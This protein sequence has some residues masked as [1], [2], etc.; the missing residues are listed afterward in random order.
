MP[1]NPNGKFDKPALPYPDT[2]QVAF[3]DYTSNRAVLHEKLSSTESMI[4]TIWQKLLPDSQGLIGLDDDFF[5]LGGHSILATRL[6]FELRKSLAVNAPLDLIFER[7]TIRE[8]ARGLDELRNADLG[9][10]WKAGQDTLARGSDKIPQGTPVSY[11][12]DLQNLLLTLDSTYAP[13]QS[14]FGQQPLTIFLTG[15]TGFLGIFV[16][17]ELLSRHSQVKKVICL[18][19]AN[20]THDAL[21][22][23]KDSAR[24]R[25]V[26]QDNW[27]ND[28][29]LHVV[30]GDLGLE[31][32][33][34]AED[35]WQSI[36][37]EADV[38]LHN[39]AWV[40]R[41]RNKVIK[42]IQV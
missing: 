41:I 36:A 7:S 9:L 27:V 20:D 14:D 1:L 38:V 6:V 12:E 26:W 39:G 30:V 4:R 40:S 32:F 34:L 18:V 8:L 13:L 33:G 5:D 42:S 24:H 37:K 35:T 31:K 2:V 23:I 16:L 22:R 28:Q 17:S 29:R 25:G 11:G 3:V 10:A 19:R 15:A 21:S